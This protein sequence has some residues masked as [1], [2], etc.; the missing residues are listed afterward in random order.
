[1]TETA[2]SSRLAQ[3]VLEKTGEN[4]Y[5]CYQCIKCSAG[6]P[7]AEYFDLT[8]NQVMRAVQLGREERV[9][10]S[11]AIWLCAACQ[12]C[13]TRCPQGI[14]LARIMDGL[15]AIAQ[16]QG[17]KPKVPEVATFH[18]VFLRNVAIF[19]RAYE[20]GLIAEMNLRTRQ[21]LKD[22]AMGLGMLAKGKVR[23]LPSLARPPR[24][25]KRKAQPGEIAYYPGCSLHSLSSELDES[26]LAVSRALGLKLVEPDGWTCC[27]SSAAHGAD[28][29][30]ATSL[31]M[32]NL[33]LV[34]KS[35]FTEVTAPCSACF[36]RF[37]SALHDMEGESILKTQV[38]RRIGYEYKDSLRVLSV[39]DLFQ[40]KVGMD[41]I[42]ARVTKPLHG[43]RV[44]SYYGCLL[45]R[46]PKITGADHV[47]NPRQMDQIMLSLGAEPVDWSFKTECCGGSLSLTRT[48]LA[49]ALTRKILLAAKTLGV[50]AIATSCPLCHVNLDARQAQIGLDFEMPV[51]FITQFMGLA[52]GMDAKHL[53]LG[54]HMVSV[55]PVLGKLAGVEQVPA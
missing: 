19:G 39:L 40:E 42:A 32:Q 4:A 23:I 44:A 43:L 45:T 28:H 6:C 35:G 51:L 11:E 21:P 20:L 9:L 24:H 34:E 52:F 53:G 22:V 31:P 16:E 46:P 1:M 14:D 30:L 50:D 26:T 5:L 48:D 54:K 17:I 15:K 10:N 13:T 49:L 47:E 18:K 41:A 36:F 27:G 37:K 25:P 3:A 7:L 33:A 29:V 12:T 38:A 8:P 55:K 2:I